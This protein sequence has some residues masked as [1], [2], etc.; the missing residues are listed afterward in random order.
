MIPNSTMPVRCSQRS[1]GAISVCSIVPS[2]RSHEIDEADVIEHGRQVRPDERA[3]EQEQHERATPRCWRRR[4]GRA[5]L[6]RDERHGERVDDAVDEP[7]ELPRPV[8]LPEVRLPLDERPREGRAPR[9][10]AGN[11]SC[12]AMLA[13]C[14][15]YFAGSSSSAMSRPV[16][17]MKTVSM[18][19]LSSGRPPA[20]ACRSSSGVPFGD[21]LPAGDEG[22]AVAE[23]LRLLHVVRR[24]QDRSRRDRA[25]PGAR[26]PARRA[27][28]AGR[29]RS[30]ARR[31]AS[32]PA[33]SGTRARRRPS[34]AG[35][36][37]GGSSAPARAPT[38][39]PRRRRISGVFVLH[40]RA[41]SAP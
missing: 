16:S 40:L 41:A 38:R 6:V 11:C 35:R 1:T 27:C 20:T 23:Q 22:D 12:C 13:M 31:A 30:S 5:D 15:P 29:G 19:M 3:D 28:C 34:A 32:A 9:R 7:D 4:A 2:Q 14:D 39:S 21:D 24:Q 37:R 8:A 26:T 36:A 18:L 10:A 17:S 33:T 25:G